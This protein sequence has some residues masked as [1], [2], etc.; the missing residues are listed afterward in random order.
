MRFSRAAALFLSGGSLWKASC[1]VVRRGGVVIRRKAGREC[2]HLLSG[3]SRGLPMVGLSFAFPVPT[4]FR[5]SRGVERE[6]PMGW[7]ST[8]VLS[9][10]YVGRRGR[11]VKL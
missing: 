7:Y 9:L 2:L 5:P 11:S 3:L 4:C 10:Q 1:C 6:R 8:V